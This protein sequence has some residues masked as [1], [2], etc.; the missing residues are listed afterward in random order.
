LIQAAHSIYEPNKIVMG[1]KGAVEPFAQTLTAKTAATA[2]VCS[3]Q[4]CQPPAQD[5]ATLRQALTA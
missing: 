4:A 5:A 3:G 1:N 2:W